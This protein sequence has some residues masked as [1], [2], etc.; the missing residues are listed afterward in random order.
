MNTTLSSANRSRRRANSASSTRSLRQRG[1]G[2]RL[3]GERLAEPGH[4][5]VEMMQLE[6][7]GAVD[8]VVGPPLFGSAV[9]TRHEQPVEHRQAHGALGG[10]RQLPPRSELIP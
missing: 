3:I 7:L 5:A 9:R 8:A 2:L 4:G 1:A 6:L 10:E